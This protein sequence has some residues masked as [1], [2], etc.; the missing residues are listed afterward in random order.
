MGARDDFYRRIGKT[1][2]PRL[3]GT[4]DPR[5]P[6]VIRQSIA[7]G[8]LHDEWVDE[9]LARGDVPF[10]PEGRPEGSDYSQHYIDLEAPAEALDEFQRRA[11]EIERGET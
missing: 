5:S 1:P 6:E 2:P 8:K 10:N 11:D 9:Q 4:P 7:L 3:S